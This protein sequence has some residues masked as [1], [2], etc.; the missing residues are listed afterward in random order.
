[1]L[2]FGCAAS[3]GDVCIDSGNRGARAFRINACCLHRRRNGRR[4]RGI[5]TGKLTDGSRFVHTGCNF[6]RRGC[7]ICAQI[8]NLIHQP[9]NIVVGVVD[10]IAVSIS[11]CERRFPLRHVVTGGLI[12]QIHC[13]G[14]HSGIAEDA[15]L[16]LLSHVLARLTQRSTHSRKLL[17]GAGDVHTKP[18]D[19]V[20][21]IGV[22]LLERLSVV[23]YRIGHLA[24]GICQTIHIAHDRGHLR[25][26][27][28]CLVRHPLHAYQHT[29]CQRSGQPKPCLADDTY[30]VGYRTR[31]RVGCP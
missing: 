17:C 14:C 23:S 5:N 20:L 7:V 6:R 11:L 26:Q 3:L 19:V 25:F 29:A 4:G 8:V 2:C 22:V 1:M 9:H 30:R 13:R 15:S 27:L 28:G 21:H 16:G 10:L 18:L 31:K 24:A 12:A